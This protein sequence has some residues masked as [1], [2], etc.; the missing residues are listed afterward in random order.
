MHPDVPDVKHV[1]DSDIGS[2][3]NQL[4][5]MTLSFVFPEFIIIWAL[6][7]RKEAGTVAMKY[8]EHGWTKAHAYLAIMG[9]LA[10]YD[11]N[12]A[13]RGYL[14]DSDGFHQEDYT[15]AEEIDD[16]LQG[17]SHPGSV[18]A[19]SSS[20]HT[21]ED[22]KE[23]EF[24]TPKPLF[25]EPYSCLL[26]YMLSKGLINLT[27]AEIQSNLSHGDV[28][29]KLSALLSTGW[30]LVQ[31]I[32]RGAQGLVVTELEVVTLSFALL[33]IATYVIWWD[34]PQCVRYPVRVTWE[35]TLRKAAN[36]ISTWGKIRRRLVADF[37]SVIFKDVAARKRHR[38]SWTLS[39]LGLYP[40]IF[41]GHQLNYLLPSSDEGS[42]RARRTPGN[43]FN[44]GVANDN[45]L[46]SVGIPLGI[47]VGAVHFIAWN[48]QFPD[49]SLQIAWLT[50]ASVLLAVP[51]SFIPVA[52][53]RRIFEDD[54]ISMF[55][56]AITCP[57]FLLGLICY[58]IARLSLVV[59]AILI[60]LKYGL[61]ESAYHDIEWTHYIPHIG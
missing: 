52:A 29:A 60:P 59:L 41:F 57:I 32:A 10:L 54:D 47:A 24:P 8:R 36:P 9:G 31:I 25:L 42:R 50:S 51:V 45:I 27:E 1:G 5:I 49:T 4:I 39:M 14:D 2:F 22:A 43:M 46:C 17:R 18:V 26:E 55:A 23:G 19:E 13:F 40:F 30:F 20:V 28:F 44:S 16:W 3:L 11:R 53:V 58:P 35:P 34:K 21:G 12:G 7:Q 61:P 6:R 37:N 15:L 33:N 56:A 48:S 38:M